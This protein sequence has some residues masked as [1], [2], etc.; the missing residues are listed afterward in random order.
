MN[1]MKAYLGRSAPVMGPVCKRLDPQPTCHCDD[2]TWDEQ[3][4]QRIRSNEL[5]EVRAINAT[6]PP[7][8]EWEAIAVAEVEAAVVRRHVGKGFGGRL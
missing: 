6:L 1:P 3:R 5:A 7:D 8:P 4:A 2:L